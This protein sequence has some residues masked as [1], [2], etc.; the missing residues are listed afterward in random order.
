ME[1]TEFIFPFCK[2]EMRHD[3]NDF[4]GHFVAEGKTTYVYIV[5]FLNM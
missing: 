4:G 5:Y 2:N 1:N 3:M